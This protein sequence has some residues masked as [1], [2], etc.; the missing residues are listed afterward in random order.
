MCIWAS[1]GVGLY[2]TK[3]VHLAKLAEWWLIWPLDGF[4]LGGLARFDTPIDRKTGPN[5][6]YKTGW[7]AV[8]VIECKS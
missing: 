5:M 3:I 7:L 4:A 2:A 8:M 1:W 6:Y